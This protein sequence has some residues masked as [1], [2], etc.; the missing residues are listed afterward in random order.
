MIPRALGHFITMAAFVLVVLSAWTVGRPA[1][2]A[3]LTVERSDRGAEVRID[4][5][6]FAGYL[7]HSG[8]LPAVWPII[9]PTGKPM[10]RSWP[11]GPKVAGEPDDHPHHHSLWFTHG[12]VNGIDFWTD[13]RRTRQD[14]QI[15]HRDFVTAESLG[16]TAKIVT[17]ND[18]I[19]NGKKVCEDERT[20]VF[21]AEPD[22]RWIDFT[23][24]ITASEEDVA[25]GNTK[26]GSFGVRTN[27]PLTVDSKKGA[28]L[29]NNREQANGDS[30]GKFANWIDDYGPVDGEQVGIAILSHPN[31]FRHPTRWHIRTY[32][33][34]AAN[35]FGERDFPNDDASFG[36]QG[37]F[38]LPKGDQL[39]LRYRVLFHRGG[40]EE[41]DIAEAYE[42]FASD[43]D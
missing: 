33:L 41:A 39:T 35:P 23:V 22:V 8:H 40:P 25:F 4:G 11:C 24:T 36:K 38:T 21:G 13:P 16:S 26:E 20:L 12:D 1:V 9:G 5:E 17:Q 2:A 42:R 10:T 27:G 15:K 14:V 3:D 30:W 29:V 28:R 18:W 6:L 7:T 19:A 43:A 31:N 34:L 32:G 37:T